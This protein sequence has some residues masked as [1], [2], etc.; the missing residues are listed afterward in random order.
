MPIANLIYSSTIS[1]AWGGS[2]IDKIETS[3]N[4]WASADTIGQE[5]SFQLTNLPSEASSINHVTAK[6]TGAYIELRGAS[7]TLTVTIADQAL[8]S[9]YN[10]DATL[11]ETPAAYNLTQ[12]TT[13]DGSAA[14]TPSVVN[15]IAIIL[16]VAAASPNIGGGVHVDY[17]TL[18]V[19]YN[20]EPV[21][22]PDPYDAT[23]NNIIV[24]SG[25]IILDTGTVIL[26]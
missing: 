5:A 1:D 17:F 21:S 19:D 4:D 3:D 26:R 22:A 10:E 13:S 24:K 25:T 11:N 16:K 9:Y 14:W 7:A 15:G 6:M 18:E 23:S 20:V 2:D 12:R 8:S